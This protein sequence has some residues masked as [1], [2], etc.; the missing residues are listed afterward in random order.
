MDKSNRTK[1]TL[2][3]RIGVMLRF[4]HAEDAP[5]LLFVIVSVLPDVTPV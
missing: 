1:I 2:F 4:E 5:W 3:V